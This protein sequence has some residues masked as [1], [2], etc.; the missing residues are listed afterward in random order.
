MIIVGKILPVESCE[1]CG[2][3]SAFAG[4][5]VFMYFLRPW[6]VGKFRRGSGLLCS[7]CIASNAGFV[8]ADEPFTF[9]EASD[10][11]Y[12]CGLYLREKERAL[13]LLN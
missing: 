2:H 11:S 8:R 12:L 10:Q 9:M 6:G 4:R 7:E 5:L 3:T 13:N 1:C